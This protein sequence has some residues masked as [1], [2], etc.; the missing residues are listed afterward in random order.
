MNA[1]WKTIDWYVTTV[2]MGV[3]LLC[4]A[5]A[6]AA[7]A[8]LPVSID[9]SVYLTSGLGHGSG[10]VIA[11]GVILTAAHVAD[12]MRGKFPSYAIFSD[13]RTT[14]TTAPGYLRAY[15]RIAPDL[16]LVFADTGDIEPAAI[17]CGDPDLGEPLWSI[18][19]PLYMRWVVAQG[20][21]AS[22]FPLAAGG[23]TYLGDYY[24]ADLTLLPGN[25]G[26]PVFND[27]GEL[28]GIAT[29]VMPSPNTGGHLAI[30]Q[31]PRGIC[32]F[33]ENAGYGDL[34]L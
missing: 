8:S 16:A 24:T 1:W 23:R 21:V 19:H 27:A 31:S 18:G 10:V 15:G 2:W 13:G 26:G 6:G 14:P 4:L 7:L 32:N 30:V 34:L 22:W 20:Y 9:K 33:L 3:V 17:S 5:F 28:I 29:A 11:D 12:G 25:S